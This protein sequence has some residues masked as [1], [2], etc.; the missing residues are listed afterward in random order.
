MRRKIQRWG[1]SLAVR[2][3]AGVIA[4]CG[5]AEGSEVKVRA[6]G[7]TILLVP[8]RRQRHRKYRLEDLV[9][10]ITPRNRPALVDWGRRVGREIW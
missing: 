9:R 7:G 2:L 6:Q 4:E 3:P 8:Q 10:R 1:N 5:V